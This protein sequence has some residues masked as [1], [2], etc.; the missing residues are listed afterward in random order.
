MASGKSFSNSPILEAEQKLAALDD[1]AAEQTRLAREESAKAHQAEV[2]AVRTE[3]ADLAAASTKALA[4]AEA[5]LR[6]AVAAQRLVHQH[7]KAKRQA[8]AR[9]NNLV[10]SKE[11]ILSEMELHRQGSRRWLAVIKQITG[12]PGEYGDL[13]Y[14]GLTIPADKSWT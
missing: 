7:E 10:G 13:K 11:P 5:S 2:T 8:Q 1:V 3:I 9:L 4:E 14:P 12:K 6:K